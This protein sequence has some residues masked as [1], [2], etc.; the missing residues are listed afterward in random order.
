MRRSLGTLAGED[1]VANLGNHAQINLVDD[2]NLLLLFT[3]M[4][5]MLIVM[6]GCY[7]ALENLLRSLAWWHDLLRWIASLEGVLFTHFDMCD[8]GAPWR[9]TT[10]ILHNT[11]CLHKLEGAKKYRGELQVLRGKVWFKGTWVFRTALACQYP[12]KLCLKA[13]TLVTELW[14]TDSCRHFGNKDK[15][16]GV[17]ICEV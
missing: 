2:G 8:Y 13:A 10:C 9:K 14:N 4:Y 1:W 15:C 6:V 3:A 16:H 12:P 11:P 5:I 17:P 7:F